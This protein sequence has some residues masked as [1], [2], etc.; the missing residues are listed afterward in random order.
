M[1]IAHTFKT[2][3]ICSNIVS[4]KSDMAI[5]VIGI[6]MLGTG[7]IERLIDLG[8]KVNVYGRDKSNTSRRRVHKHL[9]M[10]EPWPNVAI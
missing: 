8:T 2:V 1:S 10:P 6:G 9:T 3:L 4:L 7:I 5:G